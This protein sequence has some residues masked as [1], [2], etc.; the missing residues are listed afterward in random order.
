MELETAASRE[1]RRKSI[2]TGMRWRLPLLG[3]FR[4]SSI[5]TSPG[6]RGKSLSGREPEQPRR[7]QAHH[8]SIHSKPQMWF[9]FWLCRSAIEKNFAR[10]RTPRLA[11]ENR[12]ES[13][14]IPSELRNLVRA[15]LDGEA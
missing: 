1:I 12:S 10:Y 11:G 7:E 4:L 3:D 2:F 6:Y 9:S 15:G 13:G 14:S 5:S 8:A